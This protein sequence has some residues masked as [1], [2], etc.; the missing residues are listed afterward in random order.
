MRAMARSPDNTA[1]GNSQ[2][3]DSSRH[4]RADDAK[5]LVMTAIGELIDGGKAEWSRTTTGEIELHLLTGEV[6]LLGELSVTRLA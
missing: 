1:N 5:S 6:F 4:K 2:T 3:R